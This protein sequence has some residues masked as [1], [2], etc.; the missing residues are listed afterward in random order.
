MRL[1]LRVGVALASLAPS[2]SVPN[3]TTTDVA[4]DFNP[5]SAAVAGTAKGPTEV[6]TS[7][8]TPDAASAATIT[9][10]VPANNLGLAAT[11]TAALSAA[12]PPARVST[13][14]GIGLPLAAALVKSC[15]QGGGPRPWA[16]GSPLP[17][18]PSSTRGA[19]PASRRR[20]L[21]RTGGAGPAPTSVTAQECDDGEDRDD[22]DDAA[23]DNAQG[24]AARLDIVPVLLSRVADGPG[25]QAP[26][27]PLWAAQELSEVRIRASIIANW[28]HIAR[29]PPWIR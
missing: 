24:D 14:S 13:C 9:G 20:L 12:T 28:A 8:W 25:H 26:G 18:V 21:A 4:L 5:S 1:G 2:A 7:T 6:T 29:D 23:Y 16:P 27:L 17:G 3:A 10:I 19:M 22:E 11:S 15:V